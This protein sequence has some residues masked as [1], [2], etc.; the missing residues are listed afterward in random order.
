M[1]SPR[2]SSRRKRPGAEPLLAL[3]QGQARAVEAI[4][5]RI[6]PS[7]ELGPGA[8][9]AGVVHYIDRALAGPY[10]DQGTTYALAL[11]ALEAAARS[12]WGAGFAAGTAEQQDAL[13]G[14]L[15]RGTIEGWQGP[16]QRSFFELL[17]THIREG[18]FSDPAH[19]GNR[20]LVGWRLLGFPGPQPAHSPAHPWGRRRHRR[21]VTLADR[22]FAL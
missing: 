16:A 10:R 3:N 19:G 22:G 20:G 18:L 14:D 17:W 4:A 9:E 1:A 13:L 12:Q 8:L 21:V 5:T 6:F 2:T 7:D 11:A 15:E